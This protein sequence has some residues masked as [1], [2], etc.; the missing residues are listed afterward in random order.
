MVMHRRMLLV[1]AL[2]HQLG[3]NDGVSDQTPAAAG[4]RVVLLLMSAG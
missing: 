4:T 3:T 2:W 1:T